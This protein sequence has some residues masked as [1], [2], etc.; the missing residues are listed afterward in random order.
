MIRGIKSHR[1]HCSMKEI[2]VALYIVF[3]LLVETNQELGC[4]IVIKR[5]FAST[6]FVAKI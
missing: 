5:N 6:N 2:F 3:S 1:L 4:S